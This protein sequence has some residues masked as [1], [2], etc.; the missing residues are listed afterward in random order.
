MKKIA[1]L[2]KWEF[3]NE[4]YA[5]IYFVTMLGIYSIEVLLNGERSIDIFIMLEMLCV[6]YIIAIIQRKVFSES[7]RNMERFMKLRTLLWYGLSSFVLVLSCFVFNWFEY[8]QSWAM[9][10]FIVSMVIGFVFIW[11]GIRIIN[12]IDTK[13]LNDLLSNYQENSKS[14]GRESDL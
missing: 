5:S 1:K 9:G 8:L 4:L 6:C 11:I 7:S 14:N 12:K 10:V 13:H 2:Y 3:N